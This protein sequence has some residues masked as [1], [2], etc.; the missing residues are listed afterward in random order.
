MYIIKASGERELFDKKR[1]E[2]TALRAGASARL[3]K[4]VADKVE[5]KI[6]DGTTT[7]QI[8]DLTLRLLKEKP[9]VAARYNLK[10]AI[11]ELGPSGFPFEEFFSQ[12]LQNYGYKTE[13]GGFLKGKVINHEVDIIA[14]NK[15]TYMIEAKYHNRAGIHTDTKVAM[16]TYARFL[17][18]NSSKKRFD[19]AWLVTNTKCTH[20]AIAY[21]GGVGLKITGWTYP[22]K[23]SLQELIEKKGLY[24]I[25]ILGG[26]LSRNVKEKLFRARI[27]LAK[28]LASHE[29][30][31]LMKKTGL[32]EKVLMEILGEAKKICGSQKC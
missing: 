14:R 26:I 13:V 7:K 18:I 23:H 32:G 2:K 19:K 4:K 9:E 28:D 24:P 3:A 21:A 20:N 27:V 8:L 6:H 30:D 15:L 10:R 12:I 25:T 31:D 1:I 16:Y 22:K 11:M 29:L 5:S 17:D